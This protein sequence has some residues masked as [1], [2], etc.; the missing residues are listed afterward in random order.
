MDFIDNDFLDDEEIDY[1]YER[2]R[3]ERMKRRALAKRKQLRRRKMMRLAFMAIICIA[4]V[5]LGGSTLVRAVKN[6]AKEVDKEATQEVQASTGEEVDNAERQPIIDANNTSKLGAVSVGWQTD[7]NGTWYQNADGSY[8]VSGW[9]EI[10]GSTYYFDENGYRTTGWMAVGNED[11]YF[12]EEGVY[13]ESVKKPMVA[14]TFDDGPGKFTDQLLDCLEENNAKAT[15]FMLGQNVEQFPDVAK[16]E[17]ELGM[18]LGNHT[19]DHTLLTRLESD[20]ILSEMSKTQDALTNATGSPATVMRP[21]GGAYDENVLSLLDLP[22]IMWSIDTLDWKNKS[23][24][25]I[26]DVTLN[27]VTDG[28]I[29]LMHDIHE[30]TVEAACQLIPELVARGYKLVT[31]SEMAAAKGISLEGG[32]VV[33]YMGEGEQMVE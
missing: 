31:V 11:Y 22:V 32:S 17:L 27:N 25:N 33:S 3:K 21:P 28:S 30:T 5:V 2:Q 26:I 23:V 15:F 13:D 9:Q 19:Y 24:Q 16:R 12:T 4:L 29:V 8:Y 10:D 7:G 6:K 14:L 1:E 18:E 20:G